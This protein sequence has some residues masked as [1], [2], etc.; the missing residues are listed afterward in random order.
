MPRF[1]NIFAIRHDSLE[2]KGL[3]TTGFRGIVKITIV[4][5][6]IVW[7]VEENLQILFGAKLGSACLEN[8]SAADVC[9]LETARPRWVTRNGSSSPLGFAGR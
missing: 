5:D 7:W 3:Q 4:W 6:P 2:A 1:A 8:T 9:D